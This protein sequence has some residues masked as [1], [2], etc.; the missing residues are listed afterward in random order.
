[1]GYKLKRREGFADGIARVVD[2]QLQGAVEQL[3]GEGDDDADEAVHDVR[4]RLKKSRSAL[5]LARY[6][7]GDATRGVENESLRGA[8]RQ[9]SGARDA[10][11]LLQTLALFEDELTAPTYGAMRDVLEQRRDALLAEQRGA[12]DGTAAIAD[13]LDALRGRIDSWA[14]DDASFTSARRG[15][16]RI[17]K[18]GRAAMDVALADGSDEDWH[19]WRKRVKDLWYSL[20]ILR[21]VARTQLAGMVDEADELSD[22]LGDHNDLAVLLEAVEQHREALQDDQA[23]ELRAAVSRRRD[24]LRLSAVPLGRRLYA[25]AP[26]RFGRR[27]EAY[28]NAR[29]ADA[30]ASARWLTQQEAAEIRELLARKSEADGAEQRRL[31]DRLRRHGFKVSELGELVKAAP[32]EFGPDEFDKLV[33]RGQIR[34]GELPPARTFA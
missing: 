19:E 20:R 9:L 30:A 24:R 28:W 26:R 14:L 7:L 23:D 31:G 25:E 4:K 10:Q 5:R 1:M 8:G 17:H 13:E 32:D 11:V 33:K 15:L 6:D 27:V 21:P 22:I 12:G 3:R 34:I 29:D 18:R 16:R 2:E